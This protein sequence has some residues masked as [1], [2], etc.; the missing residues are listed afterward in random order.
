MK[1]YEAT[2][3][4]GNR[5]HAVMLDELPPFSERRDKT[6]WTVCREIVRG[7]SIYKTEFLSPGVVRACD[8][9]QKRLNIYL[10]P[11]PLPS[12]EAR[13]EQVLTQLDRGKKAGF[14]AQEAVEMYGRGTAGEQA[15]SVVTIHGKQYRLS[16]EEA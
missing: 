7:S 8:N 14:S 2:V 4:S 12:L 13:M 11:P 16:L 5:A 6:Y 3:G 10:N 9:C 1:A 15:T